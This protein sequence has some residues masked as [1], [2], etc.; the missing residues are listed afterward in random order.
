MIK[1]SA[2]LRN[3]LRATRAIKG[4]TQVEAAESM[5]VH[6]AR[7]IRWELGELPIK[8]PDVQ[9]I[10]T[11]AEVDLDELAGVILE[12][13]VDGPDAKAEPTA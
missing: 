11:W 8:L 13:M 6:P 12:L 3:W 7:L 9:R 2:P 1:P 10:A 5:D 4:Q